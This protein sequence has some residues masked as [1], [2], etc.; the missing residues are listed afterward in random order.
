VC[1]GAMVKDRRSMTGYVLPVG[2]LKFLSLNEN[3]YKSLALDT[4]KA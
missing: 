1:S 2:T 3:D 4:G